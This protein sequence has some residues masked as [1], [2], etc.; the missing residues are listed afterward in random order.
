MIA[1]NLIERVGDMN[2]RGEGGCAVKMADIGQ[3]A[4]EPDYVKLIIEMLGKIDDQEYLKSIY[5]FVKR[6][7]G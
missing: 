7:K 1:L 6:L 2:E 3:L 5:W 4:R